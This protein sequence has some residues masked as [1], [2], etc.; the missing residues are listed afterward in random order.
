M[1]RETNEVVDAAVTAW[2][3]TTCWEGVELFGTPNNPGARMNPD[4]PGD[5]LVWDARTLTWVPL[6]Y[7]ELVNAA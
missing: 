4:N 2:A 5:P 6:S 1:I 7:W 3:P